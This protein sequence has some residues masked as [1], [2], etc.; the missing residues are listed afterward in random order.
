MQI[1]SKG[2][3]TGTVSEG[4]DCPLDERDAVYE[5]HSYSIYSAI[6]YRLITN[7]RIKLYRHIF[8]LVEN[9]NIGK[10]AEIQRTTVVNKTVFIYN[11]EPDNTLYIAIINLKCTM[12]NYFRHF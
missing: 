7:M 8:A 10:P 9:L 4:F 1:I 5:S 3:S 12:V 6:I 2:S 11:Q